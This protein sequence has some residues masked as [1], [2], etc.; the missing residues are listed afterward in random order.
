[1]KHL[2]SLIV[3]IAINITVICAQVPQAFNYTG[4]ALD[5]KGKEI[6]NKN[7]SVLAVIDDTGGGS[8][9]ETHNVTT[10]NNGL[11]SVKIGGSALPSGSISGI[12]WTT[13]TAKY[14]TIA[15]QFWTN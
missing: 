6:S 1:M 5:S 12:D 15:I 2:F 3:T 8:Y 13:Q 11:F 7:I 4:I 10:N 14:L 9:Q